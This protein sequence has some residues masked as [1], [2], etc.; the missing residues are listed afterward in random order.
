MFIIAGPPGC[1]KST[2]VQLFADEGYGTASAGGLLRRNASPDVMAQI[3]RGELVD[4]AYTNS[5]IGQALDRLTASHGD[6]RV[7]L[8]G[9][10]RA[11]E[12]ARWL[13]EERGVVLDG[14][15]L[16][17]ADER[18]LMQRLSERSRDDDQF[19]AIQ[20][21]LEIFRHN[22]TPLLEYLT[23]QQIGIHEI[24]AEQSTASIAA[25]I[26]RALSLA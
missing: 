25:D 22:T 14:Y 2:Q 5:L 1:G 7:V 3:S 13:L 6:G 9:F 19:Q 15:I 26:R 21:R 10:P 24:N 8:D 18:V 11:L 23:A 4:I 16:L 20:Q 12:Q 17:M